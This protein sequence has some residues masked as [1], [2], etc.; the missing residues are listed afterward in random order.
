MCNIKLYLLFLAAE[1]IIFIYFFLILG[2]R[3]GLVINNN[4]IIEHSFK[5]FKLFMLIIVQ[6]CV[7]IFQRE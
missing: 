4:S 3:I 1:K 5:I 2:C 7:S 6:V